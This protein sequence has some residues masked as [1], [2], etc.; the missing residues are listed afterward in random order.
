MRTGRRREAKI[1][2]VSK[3]LE[4]CRAKGSG[5]RF[6]NKIMKII[7]IASGALSLLAGFAPTTQ[8]QSITIT[9]GPREISPDTNDSYWV[10]NEAYQCWVWT[11]PEF[12]GD[13]RGHP[14]S[15]WHK[16]HEGDDRNHRPPRGTH[17]EGEHH[18]GEHHEDHHDRDHHDKDGDQH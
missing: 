7:L 12:R 16:R 17:E 6:P 5:L 10:W 18:E 2:T 4:I 15:Y 9:T 11:G 8:A 1:G 13:Y 3:R 14:Y